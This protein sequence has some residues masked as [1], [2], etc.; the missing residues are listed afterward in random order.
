MFRIE[1]I[2]G[3][4]DCIIAYKIVE[5]QYVDSIVNRGQIYFGLLEN[6]RRMA[7]EGKDSIGDRYEASLTT[8]IM[9]CIG[10]SKGNYKEIHGPNA[11]C[12]I[13]IDKNQCAFCCYVVGLKS[14]DKGT[15]GKYRLRIPYSD[16]KRI[17][18]DKGGIEKCSIIIFDLNQIIKIYDSLKEKR[19]RYA[20]YKIMYDDYDYIPQNKDIKSPGYAL[21][22]CFHKQ[23]KYAYQKEFRIAALNTDKKPIDDLFIAV[24]ENDFQVAELKDGYDFCCC[25]EV[26]AREISPRV[27]EA[28]LNFEH[29]LEISRE[30]EGDNESIWR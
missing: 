18:E 10:D 13:Q 29:T 12:N 1:D 7:Q 28:E 21:E 23:K 2:K 30:Y 24:E 11:G 26:Q 17:C 16:L 25:V 14:F 19:L 4:N 6:Y 27:V 8:K 22:C 9:V 15:D 3:N 5:K 20:G